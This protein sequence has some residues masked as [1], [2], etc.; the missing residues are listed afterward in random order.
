MLFGAFFVLNG[1]AFAVRN[2][3]TR[4]DPMWPTLDMAWG[5][6]NW[7]A[8]LPLL[9]FA[10]RVAT[11]HPFTR[12]LGPAFFALGWAAFG[13]APALEF[14]VSALGSKLVYAGTGFLLVLFPLIDRDVAGHDRLLGRALAAA[15]VV[16]VADHVGSG[17]WVFQ[18]VSASKT[19]QDVV[20]L[21]ALVVAA[22]L[23]FDV[24]RKAR[25]EVVPWGIGALTLG[26]LAIGVLGRAA[27]PTYADLQASGFFGLGRLAG[28]AIVAAAILRYGMLLAAKAP[29]RDARPA[30]TSA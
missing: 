4:D 9:A 18:F 30:A 11:P 24:A 2:V 3:L 25:A 13:I 1:L 12:S 21:S 16:N 27:V 23:W 29:S 5:W 10:V 20:S 28:A 6:L 26:V 15:L 22:I 14:G 7:L 8:F 17:L 19:A